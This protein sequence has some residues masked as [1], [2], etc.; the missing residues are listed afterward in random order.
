MLVAMA[1][2]GAM[3]TA[4]S[5]AVLAEVQV[6]SAVEEIETDQLEHHKLQHHRPG[7][8]PTTTTTSTTTTSTTTTSTTLPPPPPDVTITMVDTGVRATHQEFTASQ[9]VA[10]WD[11]SSEG[12]GTVPERGDTWDEISGGGMP[13]DPH[14][15]GTATASAAAGNNSGSAAE[16]RDS[17]CPGCKLAVAK[18]GTGEGAVDG[19]LA[20]AFRWARETVKSDVISMSIGSIIPVPAFISSD[21]YREIRLARQA[22]ILVVLSNGNGYANAGIPGEPGFA[23]SYANSPFALGVGAGERGFLFMSQSY[24]VTTDPE[25]VSF[26]LD[27]PLASSSC[28]TCYGPATGT[29]FSAPLVAGFAA[30]LA[31]AN[32]TASA[33]YLEKLVKYSALDSAQPPMVEG[34][35]VIDGLQGQLDN[36]IAHAT[37]GTLPG[38][39]NPDI[40]GLYVET[41]Q[42]TLDS[43]WADKASEGAQVLSRTFLGTLSPVGTIGASAPTGLSDA[44]VY[45]IHAEAGEV[46]DVD[47]VLNPKDDINDIDLYIIRTDNASLPTGSELTAKSTN[48][49]GLDEHVSFVAPSTSDYYLVVLGWSVSPANPQPFTLTATE[50][51]EYWYQEYVA[52]TFGTGLFV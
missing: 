48:G 3:I 43:V 16:K 34:Y 47:L 32:P 11:F 29:S 13:Y 27:V 15:H 2:A 49:A 1:A 18:V 51:I 41:V 9:F 10:W 12:T 40:N 31:L 28:D 25:V 23:T 35:G 19:D 21:L 42:G 20:E 33:D 50:T 36:A 39:P 6:T 37:A 17:F 46:V 52:H 38:R 14:G 26:F 7:H 45:K 8:G 24:L 44:E 4:S 22:G 30:R 5:A